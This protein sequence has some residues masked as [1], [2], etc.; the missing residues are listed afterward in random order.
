MRKVVLL[1]FLLVLSIGVSYAQQ[2]RVTVTNLKG[3]TVP[4]LK[5]AV[6]DYD[7]STT[8]EEGTFNLALDEPLQMPIFV[9]T[10]DELF[11]VKKVAYKEE[12][13]SLTVEVE[14][15]I[16]EQEIVSIELLDTLD[17]PIID[18]EFRYARFRL[19]TNIKGIADL[20]EPLLADEALMPPAGYQV[21]SRQFNKDRH[22]L[23][24]FLVTEPKITQVP[25]QIVEQPTGDA[26]VQEYENDF[27][28]I[29]EELAA[30]RFFFEKK[31]EE[32]RDEILSIQEKLINEED[33][34]QEQKKELR[35]HLTGLE[36]AL[37]ENSEAIKRSEA[38]TRDALDKLKVLLIEKDSINRVAL[39]RIQQVE[40]ERQADKEAYNLKVKTYG[41]IIIGLII[42]LIISYLIAYKFR[43]QKDWLKQVNLR[44]KQLQTELTNNI[45]ELDYKT[46][47][48]EEHNQQLEVFVYKA[49]HDI[50]GPLRSI[51]GLTQVGQMEVHDSAAQEY[52]GHIH[53]ST[54]RLDN[55][56]MDLL[57]LTRTKQ[58]ELDL[59][60][61]DLPAM[62][63][64][65]IQSFANSKNFKLVDIKQ[66]IAPGISFCSD[67]KMVY[68]VVQNFVENSIKYCDPT[69]EQP[70]LDI[71]IWQDEKEVHIEFKDNGLGIAS[72]HL[73]KVF[74]MFYKINPSSDGTGL[75][76]HIVK[77][78]IEK[79][80][81]YLKVKSRAG[82]GSTFLLSF[83]NNI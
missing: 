17:V 61:I 73:P 29:T 8:N 5:V 79:L 39:G 37:D 80:K 42:V 46:K 69:K 60:F 78:T 20:P 62:L 40:Q 52:F 14:R 77:I 2:V 22:H 27:E 74:D 43:K 26:L 30:E 28:R 50:K 15:L 32:I 45:K 3:K 71:R 7:F 81:G 31:N 35:K 66:D 72:E 44:L 53:K 57:K 49:S 68:S 24:V 16:G 75:G 34:S 47:Q 36:R 55:L 56:L 6:E 82:E 59:E 58:A 23:L 1:Y 10:E 33:I 64:E 76:L 70:C 9:E 38:R 51:M 41:A 19:A 63:D 65:I 13:Q 12:Q 67:T 18:Q 11:E 4:N 83:P 48:I 21:A 54:Q 25:D